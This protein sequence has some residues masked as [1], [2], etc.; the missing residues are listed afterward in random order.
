MEWEGETWR[1]PSTCGGVDTR[2]EGIS[3]APNDVG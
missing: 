3:K 1:D 2:E